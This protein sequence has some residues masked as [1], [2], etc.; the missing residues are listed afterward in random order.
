MATI[1][2]SNSSQLNAALNSAAGGDTIVLQNGTYGDLTIDERFSSNVTIKAANDLGA[3]FGTLRI[4]GSN[5][6]LDGV[7]V[8]GRVT[9]SGA[10]NIEVTNSYLHNW[11]EAL[12][13][14]NISFVD[15]E[16][17]TTL[18]IKETNG[19]TVS[20]NEIGRPGGIDG[21]LLVVAG[22]AKNGLIE[23]NT[24]KDS[25]PTHHGDG[26][27]THADAIQFFDQASGWPSDI[28]IRGNFIWDDPS[29]GEPGIWL[30]GIAI[31]GNNILIEE[32]LIMSGTPNAIIVSHS[33]GG[34]EIL[35]NTVLP[36]PGGGGGNIRVTDTARNVVVDGNVSN[37]LINAGN[38]TILDNYQYSV[39][40]SAS[41]YYKNILQVENDGMSWTDFVPVSGS[42]VDFG[43]GYGAATRL[44]ELMNG[45]TGTVVDDEPVVDD[46]VVEEPVVEEPVVT[47][48]DQPVTDPE[49]PDLSWDSLTASFQLDGEYEFSG[50]SQA[51]EFAHDAGLELSSASISLTFNADTVSGQHGIISKDASYFANGGHFTVYIENGTLVIRFQDGDSS[52]VFTVN[53]IQSN[54]DYELEIGF[55]DGTVKAMLDGIV[56]GE[57]DFD[58]TWENNAE[59]L[60]IGANGWASTSGGAGY[61]QVFDGTISDVVITSGNNLTDDGA[62]DAIVGTVGPDDLNGTSGADTIYGAEGDD[63]VNGGKG[64]DKLGGGDG[65]DDV[66]GRAGADIIEGGAGDD[67]LFGGVGR[68]IILGGDGNDTIKGGNGSDTMTG[69][70]GADHFVFSKVKE[71][72]AKNPDFILDFTPGVDKL[73]LSELTDATLDV[74]LLQKYDGEGPAIRT[75]ENGDNTIVRVDVDGDRSS[76][77]RIILADVSGLTADD[78]LL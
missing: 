32:N 78:F 44:T 50:G 52:E 64:S 51:M 6:T 17:Y 8:D 14:T 25:A 15:N 5:V 36:W 71:S 41:N 10:S 20:G 65:D 53:G 11:T 27:Y 29:T 22:N 66:I 18:F 47:E 57:A 43:S 68:D 67:F 26:T 54:V 62:D 4:T 75:M 34:I 42:A 73:D 9:V 1:N 13:G 39:S 2:V 31:G 55:G 12:Q 56:V 24:L 38:A 76:D 40:S 21:D 58:M 59:Y 37:Y 74:L 49:D 33:S 7:H 72:K 46:P 61:N 70:A 28:T 63:T 35:N 16:F 23:N 77:M 48:P 30:Q 60:Q 3:E 45:D 69:G 19:F